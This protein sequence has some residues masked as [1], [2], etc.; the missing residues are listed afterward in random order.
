MYF[1]NNPTI[2][3]L[4][5]EPFEDKTNY[6][7]TLIPSNNNI[8]EL[9]KNKNINYTKSPI[10]KAKYFSKLVDKYGMKY[11]NRYRNNIKEGENIIHY[12]KLWFR[13]GVRVEEPVTYME[14]YVPV[15]FTTD[16]INLLSKTNIDKISY[17]IQIR[18]FIK[19][20]HLLCPSYNA[21]VVSFLTA[22]Y[23]K[24]IEENRYIID[25]LNNFWRSKVLP[26]QAISFKPMQHD[27]RSSNWEITAGLGLGFCDEGWDG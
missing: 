26:L 17:Y 7:E 12:S 2:A 24:D 11:I 16:I 14:F 6:D 19:S 4:L 25:I 9:Q 22:I 5:A 27:Y 18:P 23:L 15:D 21:N 3:V 20:K 8:I 1:Y 13:G 10:K